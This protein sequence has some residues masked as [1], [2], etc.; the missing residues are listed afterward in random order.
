MPARATPEAL[1]RVVRER[2]ARLS[3]T[4]EALADL[5]GLHPT[6]LSDIER[7]HGNPSVAKLAD[8]AGALNMRASEL[9]A[10]AENDRPNRE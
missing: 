2:R 9:L 3:L 8:L 10:G 1:G 7:G 4:I 5:A 6:Y